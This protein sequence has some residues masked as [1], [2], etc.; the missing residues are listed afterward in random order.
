MEETLSVAKRN[1]TKKVP[2][3]ELDGN[4]VRGCHTCSKRTNTHYRATSILF[5]SLIAHSILGWTRL[6]DGLD[7][8]RPLWPLKV[9][10]VHFVRVREALLI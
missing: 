1:M 3:L 9:S 8:E 5:E 2:R 7:V 10:H 6:K 4:D